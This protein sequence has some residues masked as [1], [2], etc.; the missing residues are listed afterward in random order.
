MNDK[1]G[2]PNMNAGNHIPEFESSGSSPGL[3][4]IEKRKRGR[5]RK[6]VNNGAKT[7]A[8]R[9]REQNKKEDAERREIVGWLIRRC[10]AMLPIPSKDKSE[11]S[12]HTVRAENRQY[13][14]TFEGHLIQLSAES[15]QQFKNVLEQTPDSHGRLH[16]ERSGEADRSMGLSEIEQILAA[17]ERSKFFG[18]RR[19]GPFGCGPDSYETRDADDPGIRKVE[20]KAPSASSHLPKAQPQSPCVTRSKMVCCV[21]DCGLLGA[22]IHPEDRFKRLS[23]VRVLCDHHCEFRNTIADGHKVN[24]SSSHTS[25]YGS[26]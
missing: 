8:Y 11:S 24:A 21:P 23:E 5:P 4:Q 3:A 19:V 20:G 26:F 18:G 22:A 12:A 6:H 7:A 9:R 25:I 1:K 15:L 14:K 2:E 16:N 10:K 13:L 17:Q